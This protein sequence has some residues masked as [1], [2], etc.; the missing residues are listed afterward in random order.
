M[1]TPTRPPRLTRAV[2]PWAYVSVFRVAEGLKTVSVI[3]GR[4][5]GGRA[6]DC[7][8]RAIVARPS[9]LIPTNRRSA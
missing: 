2:E 7:A 6:R 3:G 1:R 9:V 5:C 8:A 4:A